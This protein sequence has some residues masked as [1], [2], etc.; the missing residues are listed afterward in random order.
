LVSVQPQRLLMSLL[1][2][3]RG[4]L[5][6]GRVISALHQQYPPILYAPVPFGA[7]R[8]VWVAQ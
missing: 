5:Q 6:G 7:E 2:H 8:M 4:G 1:R 3:L